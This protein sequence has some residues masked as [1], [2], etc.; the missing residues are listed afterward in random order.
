[1]MRTFPAHDQSPAV[2]HPGKRPLNLPAGT[3]GLLLDRCVG[4]GEVASLMGRLLNCET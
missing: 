4:K 3:R 1:M 2:V